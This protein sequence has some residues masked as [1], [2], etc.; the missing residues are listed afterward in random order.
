MV[1]AVSNPLTLEQF[2]ALSE[3]DA[4]PAWELTYGEVTQKPM[5]GGKHSRLRSR[6]DG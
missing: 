5:P 3:I 4:L 2:L 1:A 6:Y